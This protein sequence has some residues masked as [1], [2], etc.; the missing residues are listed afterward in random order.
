MDLTAAWAIAKITVLT[1][2]AVSG[3]FAGMK[4]YQGMQGV[5]ISKPLRSGEW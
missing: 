4:I 1:I 2:I 3:L 5:R